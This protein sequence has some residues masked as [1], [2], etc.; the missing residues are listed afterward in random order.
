MDDPNARM[1]RVSIVGC[2]LVRNED[3]FVERAVRN[4]VEFCDRI[5]IA[6]NGSTDDTWEIL[7]GLEREFDHIDLRRIGNVRH[8]QAMVEGYANTATWVFG[9]DGDELYDPVGLRALREELLEG[10]YRD[11]FRIKSN[12]LNALH[13]DQFARTAS[14]YL[15]PPS[16]PMTK[17][18]NFGAVARWE[19]PSEQILHGGDR[20]FNESYDHDVSENIGDRLGWD[21][22][23]FRCLHCCFVRR[24][25]ADAADLGAEGRLSPIDA[26]DRRQQ[27]SR[28]LRRL[29]RGRP[30]DAFGSAWKADKY[31][32]GDVVTIDATPFL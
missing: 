19:G 3:V 12:V 2:V 24:S 4:A 27:S 13:V 30:S 32:R 16:R 25:S 8:S 17:L 10:R 29:R 26:N 9:V 6:D 5:H 15:A 11:R 18:F 1:S 14:G 22:S 31:R 7:S 20:V 21:E 28:I 23:H